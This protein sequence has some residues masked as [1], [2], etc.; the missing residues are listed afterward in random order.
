MMVNIFSNIIKIIVFA[1]RTDTLLGVD[2]SD[3]FGHVTVGIYCTKK[4]RLE[5]KISY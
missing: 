1:T 3:I 2:R 5:L 4:D